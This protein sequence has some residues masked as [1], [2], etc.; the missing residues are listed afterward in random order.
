M[1]SKP[2]KQATL[3]RFSNFDKHTQKLSGIK[4]KKSQSSALK[5]TTLKFKSTSQRVRVDD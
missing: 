1:A 5:Q 3:E 4:Q 2:T